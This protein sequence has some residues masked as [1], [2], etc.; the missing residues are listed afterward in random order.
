MLIYHYYDLRF[1]PLTNGLYACI[2]YILY[3]YYNFEKGLRNLFSVNLSQKNPSF[4]N[5][6]MTCQR[7]N[8]SRFATPR[9][10]PGAKRKTIKDLKV[11]ADLVSNWINS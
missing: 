2:P 4:F 11:V 7:N 3:A 10:F 8:V 9:W 1:P 6:R 5:N